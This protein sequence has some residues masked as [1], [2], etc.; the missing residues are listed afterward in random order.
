M[1]AASGAGDPGHGPPREAF[2]VALGLGLTSFGGPVA[3]IG[4][5]RREYVER[6]LWLDE[7]VFGDLVARCQSL[8]GPASSQLG[9]AIGSRRAGIAGG[10]AAWLGFTFPSAVAMIALGLAASTVDVSRA[11]WVH[12]L[13]LAAVAVVAQAVWSMAG[14]LAPDARRRAIAVVAA[15]VALALGTPITQVGIIAG[16]A[17]LGRLFLAPPAASRAVPEQAGLSPRAGAAALTLFILLLVA[18]P[19]VARYDGGPLA[20]LDAFY[21]TGALVFGGGHVVL[22]LLQANV[23]DRGWVSGDAFLAGYGAA[24]A[25]P[26]PLFTL[27]A[28]LGTVAAVPP[29]G[30]TGGV[31]GG[32]LALVAIFLPSFLLIFGT[33]P[34]WERLRAW[35]SFRRAPAGTNAAA[36][37]LLAAA[38]YKPVATGA[39]GSWADVALAALGLA[40]LASR[41]VHVL[42]VVLGLAVAAQLLV[43]AA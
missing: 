22:P 32:L 3:H 24:Q 23:V 15:V 19:L 14:S 5:F 42:A 6:R 43:R 7:A 33:L 18:L 37:G 17:V 35:P 34:F 9:I 2:R 1:A 25:L 8:P 31:P 30:A 41:R 21:R 38:L 26:G 13:K 16:G 10:L 36:V 40:V 28:F 39:I 4:Y 11:G 29:A 27:S 12:G 20:L